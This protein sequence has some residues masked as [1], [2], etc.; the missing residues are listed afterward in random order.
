[1]NHKQ[2]LKRNSET[3]TL[4][5]HQGCVLSHLS[6]PDV[7]KQSYIVFTL[8]APS[9]SSFHLLYV[10]LQLQGHSH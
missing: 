7:L 10:T 5:G 4:S 2:K 8:E 1:M 3:H 6:W 9:F